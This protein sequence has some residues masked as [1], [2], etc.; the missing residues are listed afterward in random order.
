M[1]H[2]KLVSCLV[3]A[4]VSTGCQAQERH[5]AFVGARLIP[6]AGEEIGR[7]V[8]VVRD[9]V[10]TA[11]GPVDQVSIPAGAQRVD[12]TGQVIMPG[13]VDTH[14]HIGGIGG[15]DGSGPIQPDVRIFDSIN[16]LHSGFRRAVAGGLT[17]LNIMPGS[18]H[19]LSGQTIYVKLRGGKTIE[20][21]LLRDAAGNSE[22]DGELSPHRTVLKDDITRPRPS[23][24][25]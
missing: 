14:S 4:L 24:P 8:L 23:P 17:T 7:G 13:L 3:A 19:L 15:G 1:E 20:D 18:G 10:I 6:I 5:F 16:V 12:A 11:V 2:N 22:C 9:G 25:T 21:V